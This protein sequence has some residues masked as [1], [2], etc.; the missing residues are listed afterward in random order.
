MGIYLRLS[1][2]KSVSK[3]EWQKVYDETLQLAKALKLAE[4][5]K[6]LCRDI[7]TTCLVLVEEYEMDSFWECMDKRIGWWAEGDYNSMRT[8]EAFYMPQ[9]LVKDDAVEIDAGDAMLAAIPLHMRDG[10]KWEQTYKIWGNKTQG[11]PYHIYL[12]AIACVIEARLKEKAFVHGD[13]TREQC[14]LAVDF[15][16]IYL[17][18][19]I[20]LPDRCDMTRLY[21]R[22]SKLPLSDKE[23]ISVFEK[24]YLGTQEAEFGEYWHKYDIGDYKDLLNYKIGKTINPNLEKAVQE[25][26]QFY[27]SML[28][29]NQYKEL[30]SKSAD[31]RCRWLVK[32][33]TNLIFRDYDWEKIFTKIYEKEENFSRY[34]PMV[35]VEANTRRLMDIVA[36]FVLNDELYEYCRRGHLVYSPKL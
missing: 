17:K 18:E 14:K 36:A 9:N 15:A 3:E 4:T 5:R 21:K 31:E 10:K 20:D 24:L 11:E 7:E 28:E 23:K 6:V 33:N 34:Y 32:R 13:I 27:Q 29:D 25:S 1:I 2:S 8:A 22:V 35:C 12:L 26:F 16:N 19:P 30:L